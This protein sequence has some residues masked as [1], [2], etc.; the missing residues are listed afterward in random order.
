MV[1]LVSA[2]TWQ[3]T[4]G[5]LLAISTHFTTYLATEAGRKISVAERFLWQKDFC[6]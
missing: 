6:G 1:P 3:G 5:E 4:H 2:S